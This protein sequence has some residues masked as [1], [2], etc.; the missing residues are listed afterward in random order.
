M[1][2]S[3]EYKSSGTN[4]QVRIAPASCTWSGTDAIGNSD[5]SYYYS[6]PNGSTYHNDGQGNAT[7]TS[8]SGSTST[9]SKK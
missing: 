4:S 8:S 1:P 5:G 7:Y 3:Y 9:S 6:N 2:D